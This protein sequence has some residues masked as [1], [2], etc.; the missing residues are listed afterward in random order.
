MKISSWGISGLSLQNIWQIKPFLI[1][2]NSNEKQ[3]DVVY[4]IDSFNNM[5]F[6]L[7]CITQ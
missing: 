3:I 6:F 2:T 7:F 4:P 5:P 1:Q